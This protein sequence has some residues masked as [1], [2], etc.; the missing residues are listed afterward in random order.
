MPPALARSTR[1]RAP[2][3]GHHA[4]GLR[5]G[6]HPRA[7]SLPS[8]RQVRNRSSRRCTATRA[9]RDRPEITVTVVKGGASTDI[10]GDGG[11]VGTSS[12][13]DATVG[14]EGVDDEHAKLEVRQGRIFVT[15]LRGRLAPSSVD[16]YRLFPGVAYPVPE[17]ATVGLPPPPLSP[18]AR[19]TGARGRRVWT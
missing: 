19:R 10:P 2:H 18:S 11:I 5:R 17:G 6:G 12:S 16:A 8:D 15:A 7:G 9:R 1:R 4:C 14:G 13:C 3:A